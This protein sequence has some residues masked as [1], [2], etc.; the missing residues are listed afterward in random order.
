M[1]YTV[2]KPNYID[3]DFRCTPHDRSL[4]G[5]RGYAVLFFANYMND[6]EQIALNFREIEGPNQEEKWVAADAPP[7]HPDWNQGGTYRSATAADLK[8]TLAEK[9]AKK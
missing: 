2:T 1:K 4:F 7:G 6:V 5:R 3:V 8:T 9:L